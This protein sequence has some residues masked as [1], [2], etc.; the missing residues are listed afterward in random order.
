[1][2]DGSPFAIKDSGQREQFDSGMVR[3]TEGDK[4]DYLLLVDGP[5]L[6]RWARHLTSGAKKYTRRNWMLAAGVDELERFRRSALR[7]MHQWLR[8]ERD[9]DHAAAVIFNLN[10]AEYV[11]A[12]LD[13]EVVR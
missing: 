8:G 13:L 10:G 2:A 11:Q 1:M 7:H 5:M 6:E 4:V 3:D 12:K 9:E